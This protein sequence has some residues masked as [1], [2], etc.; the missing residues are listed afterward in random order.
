M[1]FSLRA[2]FTALVLLSA[3]FAGGLSVGP[4]R[5]DAQLAQATPP[6]AAPPSANRV[7]GID[8]ATLE[9]V[10]T[11][12]VNAAVERATNTAIDRLQ[13]A[14]VPPELSNLR[15]QLGTVERLSNEVASIRRSVISY[16]AWSAAG[17]FALLVL[18]SVV[19]GSIV[20][21]LFRS[22]RA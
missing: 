20:A 11:I 6:A 15:Q 9:R 22:R 17:L 14:V 19:G 8:A 10:V 13:R 4:A 12:A 1:T 21:L 3:G 7:P 16:L 5:G 2:A 18:A